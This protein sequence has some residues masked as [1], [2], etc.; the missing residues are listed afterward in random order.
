MAVIQD[1]GKIVGFLIALYAFLI[2]VLYALCEQ[3]DASVAEN[4]NGVV[5]ITFRRWLLADLQ[6]IWNM[7]WPKS[8]NSNYLKFLIELAGNLAR[9][10]Y[11]LSSQYIM[12]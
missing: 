8:R 12:L 1:F 4:K 6:Y 9:M 2:P 5:R 3:K 11:L 7:I 10:A